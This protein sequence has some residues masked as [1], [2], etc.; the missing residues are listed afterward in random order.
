M[1]RLFYSKAHLAQ[2]IFREVRNN[3][4]QDSYEVLANS[5]GGGG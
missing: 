3:S 1:D 5:E 2:F 4:V